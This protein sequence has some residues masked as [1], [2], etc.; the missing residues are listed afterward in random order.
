MKEYLKTTITSSERLLPLI[1]AWSLVLEN[2]TSGKTHLCITVKGLAFRK[3]KVYITFKEDLHIYGVETGRYFPNDHFDYEGNPDMMEL[4]IEDKKDEKLLGYDK[5]TK[6][7]KRV[8][9]DNESGF[10]TMIDELLRIHQILN[11]QR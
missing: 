2:S 6:L 9:S 10:S 1:N 5:E 7:F 3:V 4:S 8:D 11:A